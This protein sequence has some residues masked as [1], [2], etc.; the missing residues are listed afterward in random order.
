[1]V[2]SQ[3]S[4]VD[5]VGGFIGY[6]HNT[7]DVFDSFSAGNITVDAADFASHIG[8]FVGNWDNGLRLNVI[9]SYSASNITVTAINAIDSVGGLIG[10]ITIPLATV[11]DSWS[12]GL[13][14]SNLVATNTGGFIGAYD[15]A[16]SFSNNYFDKTT[17][18]RA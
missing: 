2:T 6:A 14:S 13:V 5:Y 15:V 9:S 16:T 12:A 8:G 10:S 17:S 3:S 11:N 4:Y 1:T 7:T 18:T